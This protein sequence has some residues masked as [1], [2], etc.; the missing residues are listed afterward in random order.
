MSFIL[1]LFWLNTDFN[2]ILRYGA[3]GTVNQS[4]RNYMQTFLREY[5]QIVR[6]KLTPADGQ[7]IHGIWDE[8]LNS[9]LITA[10][11]WTDAASDWIQNG[12]YFVG[13]VVIFG[14]T[15]GVPQLY[16]CIVQN[17]GVDEPPTQRP[18][19]WRKVDFRESKFYNVWTL[20]FSE[21]KDGFTEFYTF[22]PKI[23]FQ[24]NE[25]YFSSNPAN[26]GEIWQHRLGEP[27]VYYGQEHEGFKTYVINFAKNLNKK[28][29]AIGI[30]S[31]LKPFKI[32]FESLF[33]KESGQEVRVTRLD[34]DEFRFQNTVNYSPIKNT[35]DNNGSNS[36]DTPDIRGIYLKIKFFFKAREK[37]KVNDIDVYT[38]IT[39][40]NQNKP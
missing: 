1:S 31:L 33:I 16:E 19:L 29:S 11:A 37:Q 35:L 10:R 40:R 13:G 4:M 2:A 23:Y 14:E 15:F 3:D 17:A 27:L 21:K 25:R 6:N 26:E 8:Q 32:I 22:Y 34:R 20:V 36:G 18:D 39:K 5:T 38:R 24:Q 28:F 9:Y 12:F 30:V 7:G